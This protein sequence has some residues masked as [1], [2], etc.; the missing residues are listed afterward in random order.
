MHKRLSALIIALVLVA[1]PVMAD[2]DIDQNEAQALHEK[3]IILSLE[4]ILRNVQKTKGGRVMEV[5]LEKK[6]GRYIYEIE[7]ADASGQVW[8]LKIDASDGSLISQEQDD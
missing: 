3:G 8:E 1:S 6:H 7:I 5:E 2:K 4:N